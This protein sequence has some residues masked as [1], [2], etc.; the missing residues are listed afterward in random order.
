MEA[1]ENKQILQHVF[2]ETAKGNG[3]AFVA[4]LA[5]SGNWTIIGSTPW[6][7]TYR[8]KAEVLARLLAPLNSQLA[9]RNTITAQSFVAEGDQVV[10]EGGGHNTTK[11]GK[12][13]NNRY[14]WV[15]RFSQ[16]QVVELVEYTDTALIESEL[17]PPAA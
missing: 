14:C 17:Q 2:A 11:T 3:R 5:E 10:V 12:Q 6:S 13:Y 1:L 15:F 7:G 4:A 16:G 9:H 8:S